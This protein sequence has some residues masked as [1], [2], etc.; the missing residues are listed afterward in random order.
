M[1][2]LKRNSTDNQLNN[3]LDTIIQDMDSTNSQIRAEAI[4][5]LGQMD[6]QVDDIPDIV[7]SKLEKALI[8][9]DSFVRGE[10]VMTL[11]FLTGELAIPL[12]EPLMDD[13]AVCST[14]VAAMSFIGVTPS[15]EISNKMMSY[16][17]SPKPDLRDRSARALGRLKVNQAK[18]L[19]LELAK[20][21]SSEA[22]RV[23]AVVGLGMLEDPQLTLKI[24]QLLQ[25]ESSLPVISAIRETLRLFETEHRIQV[26]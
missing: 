8:D 17:H 4:K 25:F 18:D 3:Q 24:R 21:D 23:G 15:I 5:K 2:L 22:V 20:S 1:T 16:L 7:H 26:Q 12:L 14:V 6:I 10:T 11:A 13:P 19:L 9:Q